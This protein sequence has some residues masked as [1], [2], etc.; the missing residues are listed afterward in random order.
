M[1]LTIRAASPSSW[2]NR[3]RRVRSVGSGLATRG[4]GFGKVGPGLELVRVAVGDG[5][6]DPGRVAQLLE[7]PAQAVAV[8]GQRLGHR[9]EVLEEARQRRDRRV[10]RVAAVG[11]RVA[12]ALEVVLDGLP[13]LL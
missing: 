9:R 1:G 13:R 6:D 3:P 8:V 7:E 5:A 11:E 12:E 10:E 2:K 4:G